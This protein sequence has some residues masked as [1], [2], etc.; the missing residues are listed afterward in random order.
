MLRSNRGF[1]YY[2]FRCVYTIQTR[3]SLCMCMCMW[4]VWCSSASVLSVA[5]GIVNV[6][7]CAVWLRDVLIPP[8]RLNRN[9]FLR[10][11]RA[12]ARYHSA[13]AQLPMHHYGAIHTRLMR[14]ITFCLSTN[15]WSACVCVRARSDRNIKSLY[16]NTLTDACANTCVWYVWS[17]YYN[18]TPSKSNCVRHKPTN[19]SIEF[20]DKLC[21]LTFGWRKET[22][23]AFSHFSRAN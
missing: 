20:R 10:D 7:L 4:T 6:R 18:R 22:N 12:R 13:P 21:Y 2:F 1:I 14:N 5:A 11:S 8:Y 9:E 23:S 15:D 19:G 3:S 16:A 17:H